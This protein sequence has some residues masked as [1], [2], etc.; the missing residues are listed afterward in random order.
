MNLLQIIESAGGQESLAR[1]GTNFGLSDDELSAILR[2][3]SPLL[4]RKLHERMRDSDGRNWIRHLRDSGGPQQFID[5][6]MLMDASA[7]GIE[8]NQLLDRLVGGHSVS[9]QISLH[10]SRQTELSLKQVQQ[11]LPAVAVLFAG[12][13]CK[14]ISRTA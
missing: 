1:A 2:S 14:G 3:A 10:L 5:R 7:V 11:V 12:A 6:P 9:E 13:V 4:I 8:G